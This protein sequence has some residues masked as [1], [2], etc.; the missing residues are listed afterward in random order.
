MTVIEALKQIS[1]LKS[2]KEARDF[3]RS[4]PRELQEDTDV[5]ASLRAVRAEL[6]RVK[7]YRCGHRDACI[8]WNALAEY[9]KKT[10]I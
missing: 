4:L 1:E 5:I 3:Y 6:F 7:L 2:R 10:E 9:D 8:F